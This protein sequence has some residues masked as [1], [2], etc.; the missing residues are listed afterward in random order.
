MR[1]I[2]VN[3]EDKKQTLSS[4]KTKKEERSK[5]VDLRKIFGDEKRVKKTF[6]DLPLTKNDNIQ[7][8]IKDIKK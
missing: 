3:I 8:K 4:K 6:N 5:M 2:I 1:K 7:K